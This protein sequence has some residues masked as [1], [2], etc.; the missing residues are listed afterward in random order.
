M[1]APH[2]AKAPS[3]LQALF[4]VLVLVALLALNVLVFGDSGLDG[5]N[6][7]ALLFSAAIAIGIGLYNK[8]SFAELLDHII[9]GITTALTAVLI[10]LL[11]GALA[12][13]WL[14]SGIVPA[15]IDHGLLLLTPK[16]FLVAACLVCC[17]VSLAT[18]SSWSTAATVGIALM[19]IGKALGFHEGMVAGAVI[20]GAYFGDKL[21]PLSDTTNLA[22]A[23]AGTDLFAHI[24]YM[25]NTTLPSISLTLLAFLAI[26]IFWAPEGGI[27]GVEELRAAINARFSIGWWLYLVPLAVVLM[28]W[29]RMPAL[30]ALFIG[31]LLGAAAALIFQRPL[32]QHLA[33]G[34]SWQHVYRVILGTMGS[35][36]SIET[37]NATVDELLTAKGMHGMLKTIWLIL[38]AMVFGGAMEGA[39]M[40]Q[41][42]AAAIL[43]RARTDG[44]LI[45]ATAGSCVLVNATASDQYL[46]IVVPGRM[47]APVYA[48]RGLHAKVLSRTLEDSG[49]VTSALVPWNTCGAYMGSVLGVATFT[50]LPFAFFNLI[51]PLMTVLQGALGWRIARTATPQG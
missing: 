9:R 4:P 30:P 43:T 5:P 46:S 17:V 23:V 35:G 28:I 19:G 20:S 12:A 16:A 36:V 48:E 38:S 22:P 29:K 50:Y 27:G 8:R 41:R 18:G 39:G 24:R 45:A 26:G 47:F 11:I 32:L 13:T 10:L 21:S 15:M 7:L 14:I 42:M 40:L 34:D 49:T 1:T 3:L 44:S 37:G 2:K 33:G 31:M 25:L 51:S 6:Q